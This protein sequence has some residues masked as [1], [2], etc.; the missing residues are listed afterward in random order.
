M[1]S[2]RMLKFV[3]MLSV[4]AFSPAL[5]GIFSTSKCTPV[6][7]TAC[8]LVYDDKDCKGWKLEVPQGELQF[9]WWSPVWYWY[10]NDI[11]SVSVR[12]GCTLTGFDDSSFNGQ[13]AT[14]RAGTK[15]RFVNLDD[16]DEFENMDEEFESLQ[17]SCN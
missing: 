3:V 11:E 2:V 13:S 6:P 1:N 4:T 15:D 10:R 17:C 16:E 7:Q 14:I 9:H 5:A 8:A 12:A